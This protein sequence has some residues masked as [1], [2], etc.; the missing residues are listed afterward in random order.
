M[1]LSAKELIQ[2]AE[3]IDKECLEFSEWCLK[4]IKKA[5]SGKK[6]VYKKQNEVVAK[7]FSLKQILM[8]F[9]INKFN[10]AIKK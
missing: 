10:E 1:I 5:P 9:K 2:I 6:Y 4:N 3:D 8:D 7:E